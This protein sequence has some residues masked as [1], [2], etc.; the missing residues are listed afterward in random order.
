MDLLIDT[1]GGKEY[2]I[3]GHVILAKPTV[4]YGIFSYGLIAAAGHPPSLV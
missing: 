3:S 2:I 1:N 4:S